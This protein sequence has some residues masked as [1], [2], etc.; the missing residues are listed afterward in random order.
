MNDLF[1]KKKTLIGM[2]HLL[3][4]PGAPLFQNNFSQT[5][6]RAVGEAKILE[7]AGFTAVLVENYGDV[8]FA[9]EAVD[10]QTF[11][12]MDEVLKKVR[13]EV[14]L[15]IGVNVL[16]NDS[17]SAMK[18]AHQN[19]CQFIRVN[20]LSG[21]MLTDQGVI[22]GKAYELLRLRKQLSS[23]VLILADVLVKHAIPLGKIDV[24]AVARDTA[25]R[26]LADALIVTGAETGKEAGLERLLAV[27]KAV[28]DRPLLVGSGININ[29]I[30]KYLAIADGAIVGTGLKID[31]QTTSPIS[32]EK[33]RGLVEVLRNQGI[34]EPRNQGI[35]ESKK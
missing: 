18:L 4:L 34:K 16:R 13:A 19:G 14:K 32:L 35:K 23:K 25:Y 11:Q 21:G 15:P 1:G 28:P 5:I 29:N 27:K 3:P 31:N 20:V 8:P 24:S 9:K 30:H 6:D 26:S 22:E 33:A 17:L 7:K 12:A 10:E 2:V